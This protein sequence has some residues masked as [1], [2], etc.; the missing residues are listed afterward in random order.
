ESPSTCTLDTV[1]IP[2][3]SF[4]LFVSIGLLQHDSDDFSQVRPQRW[5]LWLHMFFVFAAFGMSVLEIVGLALSERGTLLI[6]CPFLV[7]SEIIKVLRVHIVNGIKSRPTGL[8]AL[9]MGFEWYSP[10]RARRL[11]RQARSEEYQKNLLSA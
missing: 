4:V 1:I 10:T 2:I 8:L 6:Y 7:V 11:R 9:L 5:S 3:P